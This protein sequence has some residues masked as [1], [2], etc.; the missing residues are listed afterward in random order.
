MHPARI[1]AELKI[2]G[3]PCQRLC[4]EMKLSRSAF[5][6]TIHNRPFPSPR[7]QEKI[8]EI[9]DMPV[10]ELWPELKEHTPVESVGALYA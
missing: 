9:L 8:A 4:E 2:K 6:H 1:L 10:E 3:W 7:L 5:Y